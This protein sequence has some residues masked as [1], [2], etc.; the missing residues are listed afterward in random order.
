V[1]F[2]VEAKYLFGPPAAGLDVDLSCRF[3]EQPFFTTDFASFSFTAREEPP[4]ADSVELGRA[5]LDAEG[6]VERS[7]ERTPSAAYGPVRASLRATV[8]EKGG[9]SVSGAAGATL[10]PLP[11]YLGL[12]RNSE[13]YHVEEGAD[14]ALEMVVVGPDGKAIAGV[15]MAGKVFEIE[16]RTI[17]KLVDGPYR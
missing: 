5:Q 10:H 6:K 16:W 13:S 8:F 2:R 3:E 7:C 12:R 11:H 1:Q 4:L 14:A 17:L 9:R 15:P